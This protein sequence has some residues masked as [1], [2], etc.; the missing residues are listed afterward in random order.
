M[1]SLSVEGGSQRGDIGAQRVRAVLG[2][3]Q[4]A[5]AD[6]DSVR[7]LGGRAGVLGRRDAEARVERDGGRGAG[8][9]DEAGE[10]GERL[11]R[12]PVVPGDGDEVQ[13][14]VRLLAASRILA[15]VDVGATSWTR[16]SSGRSPAGRSAMMRL[17]APAAVALAAKRSQPYASRIDAYVIGMSGVS[18]SAR[19][20]ARGRRGTPSCACRARARARRRGG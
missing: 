15:S 9:V 11:S 12:A 7:E 5:G 3:E 18:G 20:C 14:P 10:R 6:D 16:R 13:P 1:S 8:A 2:R 19:A 4:C 17:V